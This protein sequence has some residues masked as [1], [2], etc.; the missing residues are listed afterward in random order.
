MPALPVQVY[1]DNG[2]AT[3]PLQQPY[4]MYNQGGY[5]DPDAERYGFGGILKSIAPVAA[6]MALAPFS[7]GASLL[8][9]WAPIAGGALTGFGLGGFDNIMDAITGGLA[10]WAGGGMGGALQTAAGGAQATAGATGAATQGLGVM[11]GS[12]MAGATYGMAPQVVPSSLATT[13]VVPATGA[14]TTG[15]GFRPSIMDTAP[16]KPTVGSM[17]HLPSGVNPN[18]PPSLAGG[19][20]PQG[21]NTFPTIEVGGQPGFGYHPLTSAQQTAP[22]QSFGAYMKDKLTD[23]TTLGLG[24]AG[25]MLSE[26]QPE[27]DE[28]AGTFPDVDKPLTDEERA[29]YAMKGLTDPNR[30]FQQPN[31]GINMPTSLFGREGGSV[32]DWE[33]VKNQLGV[34]FPEEN[35]LFQEGGH[36]LGKL[37][38]D[39]IGTPTPD[40]GSQPSIKSDTVIEN[41]IAELEPQDLI[42]SEGELTLQEGLEALSEDTGPFNI[43]TLTPEMLESLTGTLSEMQE[44]TTGFG[45]AGKPVMGSSTPASNL[46]TG[47]VS[48]G[49]FGPSK[50]GPFRRNQGGPIP[51]QAGGYTAQ[52]GAINPAAPPQMNPQAMQHL[53]QEAAKGVPWAVELMGKINQRGQPVQQ[54]LSPRGAPV[55]YAANGGPITFRNGDKVMYPDI[56]EETITGPPDYTPFEFEDVLSDADVTG[57]PDYDSFEFED[58]LSDADVTEQLYWTNPETGDKFFYDL[59]NHE[60]LPVPESGTDMKKEGGPILEGGSFV[61]PADVVSSFGDGSS[62]EGHRKLSQQFGGFA[63]GGSVLGGE[64]KGP[65]GGL[66]DLVQSSIE[67]VRSAR[68]SNDEFVIPSSVVSQVGGGNTKVGSEKLYNFIKNV[69]LNKHG[70]TKQP[71]SINNVGIKSLLS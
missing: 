38:L 63:L 17:S 28:T 60:W 6:G 70:T 18:A 13:G 42:S 48:R 41:I 20:A 7:G 12:P 30:T 68:V 69:R 45:G 56:S 4:F 9:S 22:A 10:G 34:E 61:I 33:K 3:L 39:E 55:Q 57:P 35:V 2:L 67:G 44:E 14:V 64:I 50:S 32:D 58:G 66:D 53:Q 47:P 43:D 71:S 62:D 54:T 49:A 23:P 52:M 5:I 1:R 37:E 40:I 19:T 24:A 25:L 11:G 8:P 51:F 59:L 27:F 65:G 36:P 31:V 21:G 46:N 15:S 29:A 26:E 16:V